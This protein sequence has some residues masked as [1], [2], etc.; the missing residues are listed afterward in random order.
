MKESK[1]KIY[2][3]YFLK[4]FKKSWHKT[5]DSNRN[6]WIMEEFKDTQGIA[7]K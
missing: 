4:H 6:V 2:N 7:N 3:K 5:I 1:N